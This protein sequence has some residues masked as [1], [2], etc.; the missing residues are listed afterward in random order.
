MMQMNLQPYAIAWAA[1]CVV[2]LVLAIMRRKI[3]EV[4]DD[5]IKLAEGEVED[6][7]KQRE[8]AT[9]LSK[10]EIWGKGLTVLLVVT[11][12]CLGVAWGL[13]QW[14]AIR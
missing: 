11:G 4:E 6:V 2:V 3:A 10:V 12:V 7:S 1:L 13:Q 9:K 5:T 8:L 14:S